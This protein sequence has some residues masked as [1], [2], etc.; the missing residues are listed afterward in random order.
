MRVRSPFVPLL[1]LLLLGAVGAPLVYALC[2]T[3]SK[4]FWDGAMGNLLATAVALVVGIPIALW[5]DRLATAREYQNAAIARNQRERDLLAMLKQEITHNLQLVQQRRAN[6]EAVYLLPL[7]YEFWE[8]VASSGDLQLISNRKLLASLAGAYYFV[9]LVHRIEVQL[10]RA[11]RSATVDFGGK[12]AVDL[13]TQDAHQFLER[14]EASL[15]NARHELD[16]HE[17]TVA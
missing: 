10:F 11:L 2:L 9:R 5:L 8:A 3:D 7:K 12:T 1:A 17:A 15:A 6:T 16:S 4:A 13:L 14:L